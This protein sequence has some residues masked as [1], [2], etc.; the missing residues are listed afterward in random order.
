[1]RNIKFI[2]DYYCGKYDVWNTLDWG[3]EP[4]WDSNNSFYKNQHAYIGEFQSKGNPPQSFDNKFK[5]M[6]D[7][8][9]TISSYE[10]LRKPNDYKN[11]ALFYEICVYSNSE[12]AFSN[13]DDFLLDK[14]PSKIIKAIQ[15]NDNVFIF[16]NYSSEGHI[17]DECLL[18]IHNWVKKNIPFYQFILINS[19]YNIFQWYG[20]FLKK[21]E[22]SETFTVIPYQWSFSQFVNDIK[23]GGFNNQLLNKNYDF[24][25][26]KKYDFNCLMRNLRPLR[27]KLLLDF[28]K[29]GLL[30]K[31]QISYDTHIKGLTDENY[32]N[33]IDSVT[34]SIDKAW[35]AFL[36]IRKRKPK[37][38]VDY[39]DLN[40]IMGI[41]METDIPYKNSMFTVV[42][43]THFYTN[44]HIGYISEKTWKP[45]IHKHPF[46][47]FGNVNVLAHLQ[48]WGFK[49][50]GETGFIDESYD[51]EIDPHKRYK[52]VMEQIISL[53]ELSDKNKKEFMFN[54]SKIANF[55]FEHFKRFD[56]DA[57]N[58]TFIEY[59]NPLIKGKTVI[60]ELF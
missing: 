7:K 33:H 23:F 29:L 31:N 49:T 50:Y 16:L 39:D 57:Y 24:E 35:E 40:E 4:Y 56:L 45:I 38:T 22:L 54:A 55:N 18:N 10:Y 51:T 17:A 52:M 47:I 41:G 11:D 48:H 42:A 1:M 19:N 13:N 30:H 44:P 53:C 14:I 9:K 8:F 26:P 20:D 59:L 34:T 25:N 37:Q 2:N 6:R 21:N 32:Y 46:L 36:E 60:K 15:K 58:K 3:K 28:D 43:E 27:L 12:N 5:F